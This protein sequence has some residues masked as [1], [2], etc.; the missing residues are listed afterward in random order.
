MRTRLDLLLLQ[1]GRFPSR[2]KARAAIMAGQVLV[3]GKRVDKPGALVNPEAAVEVRGEPLPYVS[4]GGI[5]L[6]KALEEFAIDLNQ[7]RVLDVGSSTGGFTDCALQ[8]GA[9]VVVAVDVG[10]GQLA[11]S[12]RQDP[13]VKVFERTNIRHLNREELGEP[14]EVAVIDVSFI[15]LSLVLPAVKGLLTDQGQVVALIKPQFEA[16]REKVGKH[17]VVRDPLVHREV[18]ANVVQA[19]ADNGMAFKALTYSPLLGPKGNIEYLIHLQ[20]Q[21][22]EGT[23]GLNPDETAEII[24]RVVEEAH[25]KLRKA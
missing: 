21:P 16:G 1:Q 23:A 11:W 24:A 17:G 22:T 6:K 7:R 15:S 9:A 5:K 3:D 25:R 12:L 14:A 13:R 19:A 2:E 8:Q 10:Y 4:R 20:K 18:I